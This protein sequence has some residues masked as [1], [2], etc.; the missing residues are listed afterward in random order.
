MYVGGIRELHEQEARELTGS[1]RELLEVLP[2]VRRFALG[3]TG[4]GAAADRLLQETVARVL[5][6]GLPAGVELKPR[7]IRVCRQL[8]L[9]ATGT[10]QPRQTSGVAG[11]GSAAESPEHARDATTY[12]DVQVALAGLSDEER[13]VLELVTVEKYSY[14]AAAAVLDVPIGRVMHRLARARGALIAHCRPGR[15][16]PVEHEVAINA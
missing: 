7:C 10:R 13:A 1:R 14:R 3:L 11:S 2:A 5:Q 15:P 4:D 12:G 6:A 9:E 16:T 8:W